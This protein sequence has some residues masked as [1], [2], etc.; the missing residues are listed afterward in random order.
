MVAMGSM[1]WCGLGWESTWGILALG[2]LVPAHAFSCPAVSVWCKL[3]LSVS[4]DMQGNSAYVLCVCRFHIFTPLTM[5]PR[6]CLS[7]SCGVL[8]LT[9]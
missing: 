4:G 3:L 2:H 1:L 5:G 9:V 7:W 8:R 6:F